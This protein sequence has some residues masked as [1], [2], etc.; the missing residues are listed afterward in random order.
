MQRLRLS[1][2]AIAVLVLSVAA[3]ILPA[4][5]YAAATY[6]SCAA[7]NRVYPHGVG[8]AGGLDA[9]RGKVRRVTTFTLDPGTYGANKRFDTDHDGIA[10][11]R[12]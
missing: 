10:C 4:P 9:S 3:G 12:L 11:E 5:A 1:A 7:L 2:L 8:R 6:P